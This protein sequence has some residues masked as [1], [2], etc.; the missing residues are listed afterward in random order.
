MKSKVGNTGCPGKLGTLPNLCKLGTLPNLCGHP[1][2]GNVDMQKDI[3][4]TQ[5][6]KTMGR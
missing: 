1:V 2:E 3:M 6:L 5:S 4:N